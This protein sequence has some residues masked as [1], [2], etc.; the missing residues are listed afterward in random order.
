M[1]FLKT[2][3]KVLFLT[4]AKLESFELFWGYLAY[5]VALPEDILGSQG[6]SD[7]EAFEKLENFELF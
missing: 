3:V 2:D 1:R 6:P 4:L 5:F 7:I